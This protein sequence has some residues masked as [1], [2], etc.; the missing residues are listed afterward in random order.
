[1]FLVS[2][3]VFCCIFVKSCLFA[4]LLPIHCFGCIKSAFVKFATL[5][6][7]YGIFANLMPFQF[8]KLFSQLLYNLLHNCKL[9]FFLQNCCQF[10]VLDV[11]RK[12]LLISCCIFVIS[13]FCKPAAFSVI[14]M[15]LVS[16]CVIAVNWWNHVFCANLLLI[17]C[18][19]FF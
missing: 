1:M 4:N 17:Q 12:I 14:N 5:L 3:C 8:L 15:F 16:F 10:S 19:E 9:M 6:W 13:C 2:F 7:N 18:F 11:Y